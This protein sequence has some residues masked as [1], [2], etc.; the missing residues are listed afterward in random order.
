MIYGY[1]DLINLNID[2]TVEW[3]DYVLLR[4]KGLVRKFDTELEFQN[5]KL[6]VQQKINNNFD[7]E[8][9]KYIYCDSGTAFGDVE[10]R[11]SDY[12]GKSLLCYLIDEKYLNS[13]GNLL[14]G[15]TNNF[16][17][18][19][20]NYLSMKLIL[21]NNEFSNYNILSDSAIVVF[22]WLVKKYKSFDENYK[23]I[24]FL[25]SAMKLYDEFLTMNLDIGYIPRNK[26]PADLRYKI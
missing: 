15:E 20:A 21:N 17:E 3:R 2:F 6:I 8:S 12:T 24:G 16:G 14:V 1:I 22:F 19:L 10:V 25:K 13:R 4:N 23:Y 11:I 9:K 26:N 18:L 5:W 7:L